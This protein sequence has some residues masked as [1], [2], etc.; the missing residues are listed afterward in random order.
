MSLKDR[1]IKNSSITL[2]SS[3]DESEIYNNKEFVTTNVPII[4]VALSARLDGGLDPGLHMIVGQSKHFKSGFALLLAKAY[5]DKYS[6]GVIL[7]YDSEFGTPKEYFN[8]YD[9]DMSRVI[10]TPITNVEEFTFDITK[11]LEGISREDHVLIIVDS[12][13]NLASKKEAADALEGKSSTDMTRAK[14]L[15]SLGRII[16]PHLAIRHIPMIMVGHTYKTLEMYSRDVVSGGTGLYLSSNSIWIIGRQQDKDGKDLVGYNFVIRIEKSR[17]V[18]EKSEFPVLITFEKGI[19]RW[20]G[21]LDLAL[22]GKF[23][24]KPKMGWYAKVDMDTGEILEPS[25][26]EKD[27]M[28]DDDFWKE[29]I[30]DDNFK[31]FV[32][33]KYAIAGNKKIM[34]SEEAED[35]AD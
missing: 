22:E 30:E 18:T 1:L 35:I 15:K 25:M 7:L 4:N 14:S 9:I 12:I 32:Y 29:M 21:L 34:S 33:D 31:A 6:D 23:I 27:L 24:V 20:S 19:S 8:T 28:S 26:R 3:L 16:T 11:Q 2:T 13:G 10:H 17:W 5:L